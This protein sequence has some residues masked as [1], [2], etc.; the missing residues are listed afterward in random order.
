MG[1]DRLGTEWGLMGK[2]LVYQVEGLAV[3]CRTWE[4]WKVFEW[5]RSRTIGGV[6]KL[7]LWWLRC[8]GRRPCSSWVPLP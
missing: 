7:L 3:F 8:C 2:G 6:S 4:P 5:G 1:E